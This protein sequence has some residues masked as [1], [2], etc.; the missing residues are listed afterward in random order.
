MS[1]YSQRGVFMP[2]QR[3]IREVACFS[4]LLI[5]VVSFFL[6]I[7][8]TADARAGGGHN[9]S[10]G[11]RSSGGGGRSSSG[12]GGIEGELVMLLI[13]LIFHYPAVGIPVTIVVIIIVAKGYNTGND[14]WIDHTIMKAE[15][16]AP[17]R[18]AYVALTELKKRDPDFDEGLFRKRAEKAFRIIQK[19]WTDRDISAAQ[20]FLSDGVFEQF[21]I[22][23]DE[24]KEKGIIDYMKDMEIISSC[25]VKFQSDRNFDVVHLR[26]DARAVNYRM[27]EKTGKLLN[28]SKEPESFAEIWSFIRKPGVKTL[29]KPGLIEGQCPN[30]GNPIKS[31]RL[32]KC[33]VCNALL[34]SGEYDWVL[35]GITQACEWSTRPDQHIPGLSDFL[36]LDPGFNMQHLEDRVSVMFWR[37]IEAE[38]KGDVSPLRKI[39]RNEFCDAQLQWYK[40]DN[41]GARRFYTS[42][43]VGAI[44]LLGIDM[45]EPNDHAYVEVIWSGLPSTQMP[46]K[47]I[48]TAPQ[49][50]NFKHVF[51]L[52]RKHGVQTKVSSSL[53]SA[54][55]P[56]CGAP[57]QTGIE[58]ECSYCGTVMN[59]GNSDW[60]LETVLTRNDAQVV[61]ILEKMKKL[62]QKAATPGVTAATP[63]ASFPAQQ[64]KYTASGLELVRW[65]TAMMLADGHIDE[66]ETAMIGNIAR[67]L[68]VPAHKLQQVVTEMQAK[69]DPVAYMIDTS[70]HPANAL[71]LKHLARIALADGKLSKEEVEMLKTVGRRINLADA[72]IEMLLSQERKNL[73]QEAKAAIAEARRNKI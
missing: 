47:T 10:S 57:E 70:V 41:S 54:R 29:K 37:K 38:R 22:Q 69:S 26:I 55:C 39:A 73:Y 24:L 9:Y 3:R 30:C 52:G 23:T 61:A 44:D 17:R 14:A 64:Q 25:P 63:A 6:L 72:D 11:S 65:A 34:R 13:R 60:V 7:T 59:D 20:N 43:A 4:L 45:L 50:I 42:C 32:A 19:A 21:T 58:N 15:K 66:K 67:Q 46:N 2:D 1:Y 62:R 28:G 68:D 27:E 35:A 40:P 48:R 56:S 53:A 31:G 51:V 5:L 18:Q 16:L 12:G 36:E 33:D 49:P 71:L 8:E